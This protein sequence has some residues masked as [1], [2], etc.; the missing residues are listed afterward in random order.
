MGTDG[1]MK[2]MI[3]YDG[4]EDSRRA[5]KYAGRFLN[6]ADRGVDAVVVTAW[7]STVHQAARVSAMSGVL[8]PGSNEPTYLGVEDALHAEAAQTNRTGVDLA[9]EV[10]MTTRGQLVEITS[11]VWAAIV[12]AADTENAD[13][14]VTGS[15]GATGLKALLHSSTSEGVLKHCRRPVLIVPSGCAD[16]VE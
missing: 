15:R 8:G 6:R 9:R 4:S 12:A 5:V 16:I 3:A 7:E 1:S 11:T 14:I 10:G 13:V 2:V